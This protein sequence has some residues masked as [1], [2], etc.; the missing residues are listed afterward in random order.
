MYLLIYTMSPTILKFW[1]ASVADKTNFRLFNKA[2]KHLFIVGK[3]VLFVSKVIRKEYFGNERIYN[4]D[5]SAML[6]YTAS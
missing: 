5:A 6:M 2:N 4:D 1:F 3:S